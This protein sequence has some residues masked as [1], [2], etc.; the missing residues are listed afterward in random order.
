MPTDQSLFAEERSMVAMS[1][2]DHIEELR[3][4]LILALLGLFVGIVVTLIP[5]LNLGR[6]VVRQM[7]E[8]A[9]RTLGAFLRQAG[10]REGRDCRGCRLL[11]DD[12]R[13]DTGRSVCS[14]RPPGFPRIARSSGRRLEGPSCRV[15]PGA[16]GFRPHCRRR[17]QCR[18]DDSIIAL[19]PMEPAL[20]FFRACLVTGL[21]LASPW[22]FYQVWA[23]IAAGLY[24]H[25][26]ASVYKYLPYSL[27][28]IPRGRLPLFFRGPPADASVPPRVQRL[29]RGQADAPAQRVDGLCDHSAPG[30][31]ALLPDAP[32]DALSRNDRDLHGFGLSRK[33]PGGFPDH[34]HRGRSAD[35]G[36]GRDRACCSSASRWSS[37]TNWGSC[38]SG[39]RARLLNHDPERITD[40][41]DRRPSVVRRTAS[42]SGGRFGG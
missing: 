26:R 27:G 34:R 40:P 3:R 25:E 8:P 18:R 35:A 24:R 11:H 29:A 6:R 31:R 9:Q 12:P 19:G 39:S 15:A 37:F 4:H 23:F 38:W 32:G 1:L 36:A 7:E 20:I 21:V 33:A 10:A 41:S 16:E 5:P 28:L 14:S 2:G 30:V 17:G 42:T 13:A 22:V